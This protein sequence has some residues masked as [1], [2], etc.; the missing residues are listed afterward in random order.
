[1]A[2]IPVGAVDGRIMSSRTDRDGGLPSNEQGAGM[3]PFDYLGVLI[4][5][6][7]GLG[8]AQV[9]SNLARM[10]LTTERLRDLWR[11]QVPLLW[12]VILFL[13]LIQFW[14]GSFSQ[15]EVEAGN[16]YGFFILQLLP[17]VLMFFLSVLVL[18]ESPQSRT[19]VESHLSSHHRLFFGIAALVPF[20]NAVA[21]L[22]NGEGVDLVRWFQFLSI[23]ALGSGA[24]VP[25]RR[26]HVI[27]VWVFLAGFLLFLWTSGALLRNVPSP[28]AR[29]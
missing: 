4:S 16:F 19:D 17:T 12:S 25:N 7:I 3:K 15:R 29:E 1:V 24:I 8:I 5:I 28:L 10:F 26:Y 9:L 18:P 2:V 22:T 23:A 21:A 6:V 13:A 27:L 11:C 14:W 20:L